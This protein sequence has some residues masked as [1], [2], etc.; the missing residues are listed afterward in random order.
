MGSLE[1]VEDLGG[2]IDPGEVAA[3]AVAVESRV[4]L[5]GDARGVGSDETVDV[6][7]GLVEADG[8]EDDGV[9]DLGREG[10]GAVGCVGA[11]GEAH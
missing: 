3:V 6:E 11:E 2:S 5:R 1:V 8:G 7:P 9:G 4:L 10:D